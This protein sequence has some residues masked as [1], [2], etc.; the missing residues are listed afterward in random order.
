MGYE[1]GKMLTRIDLEDPATAGTVEACARAV[2]ELADRGLVAMVEPFMS[3][4]KDGRVANVL[5]TEAAIKASA[6]AAGLGTTS[7]YTWLKIPVVE[8]MAAV[9]AAT[10]LPT[11]AA[12][13]RGA[14]GPG[15]VLR[16]LALA[17]S[18]CRT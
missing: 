15:R 10:T 13:R 6:I 8:D 1:G 12:R 17:R 16:D 11:V 18:R 5:T 14:R 7:A 4:R 2:S 3:T 9:A